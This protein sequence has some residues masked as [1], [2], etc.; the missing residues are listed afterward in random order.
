MIQ[1]AKVWKIFASMPRREKII[2]AVLSAVF[3][4]SLGRFIIQQLRFPVRSEKGIF[5]EGMVGHVRNLNPL[6]VDFSDADRDLSELIFSGLMRYDP[7]A[8]NFFPDLAEKWERSSN[9]LTYTFTIRPNILWHDKKP[10][11]T[12]DVLFT[13][14]D[15]I[16]DPGLRNPVLTNAF[17]SVQVTSTGSST[18][19]F[20]LP[21]PN[22]YFISHLTVGLLPKHI[23]EQTPIANL[24]KSSFGQRPIGTGPYMV[25]N[26]KLNA[27]GD[28]VNLSAFPEYYGQKPLLEHLRFFTFPDEETL[29]SEQKALHAVS[30]IEKKSPSV[31]ALEEDGRFNFYPY[32]LNQFT[33]LYFNTDHGLL[34]EKRFRQALAQALNKN[35]AVTAGQQRVDSLDLQDHHDDPLFVFNP[36]AAGKTLDN[37]GLKMGAE[38]FR[39]NKKGEKISLKLLALSRTPPELIET[40]RNEW[41]TLGIQIVVEKAETQDFSASVSQRMYDLLLIRQNLGYNRDVYPL[42]HSSQIGGVDGNPAGLNFANFKS[43][44]TDGITEAIR[45]EKDS[46]DKE[47]LFR[48]LSKVIA[49]EIPVVFLSTPVYHYILDKRI[50]PFTVST[51]DYHSDRLSLLPYLEFPNL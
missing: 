25:Q 11:T 20:T 49:E 42:F 41:Q 13:F 51:L 36:E 43:F 46:Q 16:Q 22:S 18:V 28:V 4:I 23:L 34:N 37:M 17:E 38:G 50:A 19:I 10:F 40:L 6:F 32:T 24:D 30:K 27:T 31:K 35:A 5:A 2:V 45:K 29:I 26:L 47:K 3:V 9:G 21:K 48:E 8:K 12:D 7:A 33:A 15:V 1:L 44:R 39:L 14:R